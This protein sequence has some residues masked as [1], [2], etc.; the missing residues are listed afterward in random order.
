MVVIA[1]KTRFTGHALIWVR[2]RHA[3]VDQVNGWIC[4]LFIVTRK[5]A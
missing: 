1:L 5:R 3:R 4:R 2:V